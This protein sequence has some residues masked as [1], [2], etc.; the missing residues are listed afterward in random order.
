VIVM[1]R[2][3]AILHH[4]RSFFP[5]DLRP[6]I[7]EDLEPIWVLTGRCADDPH[8][9]RILRRSGP[10][11]TAPQLDPDSLAARLAP[12]APDGV[13]TFVDDLLEL[14]AALAARL[15]L[16]YHS[17]AVAATLADKV[18]QRAALAAAGVP[19]PRFW[20]LEPGL[21]E[22]AL[23]AVAAE[24]DYPAVLKPAA[25]SGSRGLRDVADADELLREYVRGTS[26]LVEEY[27]PDG[28]GDDPRFAD[29]LSLE[30]VISHGRIWHAAVC[31]RFPLAHPFRETGNIIPAAIGPDRYAELAA[32]TE[33]SLRALGIRTGV[34]HTEIKLTD[35]GPRVIEVNGRLGGR[36][37]FVLRSVSD[38]NLFRVAC[39]LALGDDIVRPGPAPT[40]GVGFWLMLQPP[41]DARRL[42]A[43]A[44]IEEISRLDAVDTIS[45]DRRP[46][47]PV[48][49][50][51]GTAGHVVTVRGRVADH[52]ELARTIAHI[53]S[54]IELRWV[55]TAAPLPV[56]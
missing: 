2:R 24:I 40:R 7:G 1:S 16:P 30:S 26:A 45:L 28:A 52:D 46:G 25:G 19:G 4:P 34:V 39:R 53:E 8:L 43:V 21:D 22:P 42:S 29:Y 17:E 10:V 56:A 5:L 3:I 31:G 27:L 50:R 36:P 41:E 18:R 12:L 11:L 48:D 33:A 44:G 35:A 20:A 55:R 32:V 9:R 51:D 38:L 47:D 37:P 13:I 49:W 14:T 23:A 6:A 54:T 15:G